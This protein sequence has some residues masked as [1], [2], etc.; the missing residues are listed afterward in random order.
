MARR[1]RPWWWAARRGWYVIVG[2]RR[3]RLGAEKAAAY[4]A[5]HAIA[6]REAAPHP[7]PTGPLTVR[8][9]CDGYLAAIA[10][11]V[12]EHYRRGATYTL[13]RF[14]DHCGG[15][16]VEAVT[17][18]E[19]NA[20]ANARGWGQSMRSYAKRRWAAACNWKG[21]ANPLRGLLTGRV[22]ARRT[23]L[24]TDEQV[25]QLLAAATP[26]LRDVLVAMAD[27]GCRS[28]EVRA[29]TAAN[30]KG[31]RWQ[32]A[33][34]KNG[35]PRVVYLTDRVRDRCRELAARHPTGPLYRRGSGN[36]WPQCGS[37]L[38]NRFTRL[39]RRL[40]LPLCGVYV[41][42]HR[43]ITDALGR[44]V[45]VSVVAELVGN[46]AAVIERHYNRLR[47]RGDVLRDGLRRVRGNGA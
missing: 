34:G 31:D 15:F 25:G 45:P 40:R 11:R 12:G 2:G 20:I 38:A 30:L 5:W 3:H 33:S 41:L 28:S 7:T 43:F 36:P 37:A 32:F 22:R 26:D 9:L 24:L 18:V 21:V 39:L 29:V 8:Q 17:A 19:F 16:A 14:R 13:R 6:A 1:E 35:Q 23:P 27:T 42:R 4:R 44:G 47:D 46:T 10:G